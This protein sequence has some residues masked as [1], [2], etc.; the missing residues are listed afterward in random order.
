MGGTDSQSLTHSDFGV[1]IDV[2]SGVVTD[3]DDSKVRL[4]VALV[5]GLDPLEEFA[6]HFGCASLSVQ[7][8]GCHSCVTEDVFLSVRFALTA[9]F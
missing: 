7:T 1:H 6:L 8:L 3:D 5:E 4:D 2:R 9:A